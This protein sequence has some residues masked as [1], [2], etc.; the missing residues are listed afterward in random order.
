MRAAEN[1]AFQKCVI[2]YFENVA[3]RSR[4]K[5]VEHF[6]NEGKGKSTIYTIINRYLTT[7]RTNYSKSTGR[8]LAVDT[9][10]MKQ[11]TLKTFKKDQPISARTASK[12]LKISKSTL[13]RIKA[14]ELGIKA[15]TKKTSPKYVKNQAQRAKSGCRF[16][17]K[18]DSSG[19][20]GKN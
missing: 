20:C 18:N 12:K 8:V 17:Y 13:Q 15:R 6:Q 11:K 16:V 14:N 19:I 4:V 10:K 2:S 5:T 9:P 3:R 1:Q 7:N